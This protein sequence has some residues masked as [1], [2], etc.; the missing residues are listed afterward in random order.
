[1]NIA[2]EFLTAALNR[3]DPNRELFRSVGD[4]RVTTE[5][6]LL[7]VA[8]RVEQLSGSVGAGEMVI[9]ASGREIDFFVD[10]F[11]LWTLGAVAIPYAMDD[12]P[13]HLRQ[14][15]EISG[16][17]LCLDTRMTVQNSDKNLKIEDV[18]F[19]YRDPGE[20]CAVLFTSGSTGLP[21]G[22]VLSQH[23]L[24]NN[25]A[26]TQ[27]V[28]QLNSEQLLVNVPFHFTSAICHF[29]ASCL[30]GSTY[31]GI[32]K[33]LMFTDF[34]AQFVALGAT[35][36]GGAPVQLRWLA[37]ATGKHAKYLA[38]NLNFAFSSGDH[39]AEELAVAFRSA[40]PKCQL[41][42]AYGLTELGG[43]FCILPP[44]LAT[45][46][47]GSVGHAI[48]GLTVNIISSEDGQP[49]SAKNEGVLIADGELVASGYLNNPEETGKAFHDGT[50]YTGDMGYIDEEG[51]VYVTGRAD[52]IFKVNGKKVSAQRISQALM[53]SG[54]FADSAVISNHL[55]IFGTV[56]IACCVIAEGQ[57]FKRGPLLQQLR[58]TLPNNHIP[59]N[60]VLLKEI[61]RTGSGKVKRLELTELIQQ[62]QI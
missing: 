1:M 9:I 59:H 12:G 30:S 40:Y 6:F 29:L 18:Q 15:K 32:E 41:F 37:N 56:A 13:Q 17:K 51:F 57:Q 53:G 16:A 22:V 52:D 27:V 24:F 58:E 46:H 39:L 20:P 36:L 14:I 31:V 43:R 7:R 33:K 5:K 25:A 19:V 4:Q 55:P 62:Q 35:A 44:H 8:K 61:P 28:T 50:L 47:P 10:L 60:F 26:A 49:L 21:K 42:T 38:D 2:H 54:Y 34:V 23:V 3:H 48:P 45:A 11:A